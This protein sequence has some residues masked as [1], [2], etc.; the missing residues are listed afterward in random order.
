M[1]GEAI[2]GLRYLTNHPP[3][4]SDLPPVR[5]DPNQFELAILNLA[6]NARDAMNGDGHMRIVTENVRLSAQVGYPQQGTVLVN[7]SD[8]GLYATTGSAS[9]T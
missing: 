4:V 1:I 7:G 3:S 8:P 6:V 9:C 5:V 2:G